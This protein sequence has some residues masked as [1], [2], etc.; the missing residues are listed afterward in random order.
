VSKRWPG[1]TVIG[2]TGN[3]GTGKS[4]VRRML[5]A[6]DA[7]GIDA[8]GLAHRA[9]SPGAPAYQPVIDTFGKWLLAPDGQIDRAK[10][11]K[12]VFTDPEAL[13][14]LEAITHPIVKQVVDLLIR[15][16]K[17]DVIVIEAI[18]LFEAGMANDCDSIWVVD[19]PPDVQIKRL[20]EGRKMDEDEAKMRVA[21]QS[22]QSEKLARASVVIYNANAYENTFEQ[23]Q[24]HLNEVLGKKPEEAV[25]P[26][27]PA[28]VEQPTP[29]VASTVAPV[30]EDA[31]TA[32][33]GGPKDAEA[34]ANFINK[35]TG[36]SLSRTD[37]LVRFGQKAYMMV[38]SGSQILA[39]G[40]WQ[41]ENLITRIDEILFS[42]ST[43]QESIVS[44][45]ID[46]MEKNS[47]DLQSEVSL[48]FLAPTTPDTVKDIVRKKGYELM[49]PADL[50]IP[51]WREAAEESAPPNTTL[52]VK[53][54]RE[55]RILK[56]I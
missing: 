39:L 56:P 12:V 54:L 47:S 33:R 11:G 46:G 1:K 53:R 27:A 36:Q 43:P 50:R 30:Q 38:E 10:L 48:L 29:A 41:V 2:L 34:I 20:V 40:G 4:V 15:R 49:Q 26:A 42:E 21:A 8:D 19:V 24:K 25:E 52:N 7:F 44:K 35:V 5:E 23:V 22:P 28:P 6:L 31:L 37:V 55:D 45:L 9:M 3:I 32:K 18:K 17:K 14:R 13:Q 51:D 16:S